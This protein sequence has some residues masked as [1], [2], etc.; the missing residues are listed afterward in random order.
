MKKKGIL[1]AELMNA[2]TGLG[3]TDSCV[4]CDTGFPIPK[5]AR[6]IDLTL[7]AGIPTFRQT[8]NA[9][10]REIN[11][12]KITVFDNLLEAN[13]DTYNYIHSIFKKQEKSYLN[14]AGFIEESRAAKVFIRTGE[15]A[16][17]SNIIL[18]SASGAGFACDMF[19]AE[20]YLVD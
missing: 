12:E 7:I 15:T 13:P 16:P 4:I 2:L 18:V 9:V 19:D 11:I 17:C 10:L 20:A 1:N 3:H 8:L 14:M 6:V 5:G